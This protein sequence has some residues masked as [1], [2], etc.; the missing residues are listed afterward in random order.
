MFLFP[1]QTKPRQLITCPEPETKQPGDVINSVH[2]P[3][4]IR[5][6]TSLLNP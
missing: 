4:Y 5:P 1:A 6:N 2:L 3:I